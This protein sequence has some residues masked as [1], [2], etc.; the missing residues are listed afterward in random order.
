MK[1]TTPADGSERWDR[2]KAENR[3]RD[4]IIQQ[5]PILSRNRPGILPY[6]APRTPGE[7][8]RAIRD[9][10]NR[11]ATLREQAGAPDAWLRDTAE[12]IGRGALPK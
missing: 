4:S 8:F 6:R 9:A 11:D 10:L 5:F 12:W 1:K 2:N 7:T 3:D